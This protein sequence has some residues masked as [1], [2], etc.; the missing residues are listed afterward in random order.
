MPAFEGIV[1]SLAGLKSAE[2]RQLT[3][4]VY[5][6]RKRHLTIPEISQEIGWS[7]KSVRAIIRGSD[8]RRLC[9]EKELAEADAPEPLNVVEVVK[10]AKAD[11]ALDTIEYYQDCYARNPEELWEKKGKWVDPDLAQWAAERMGKGIGLLEP[12]QTARPTIT[13]HLGAI[14]HVLSQV[15][16]ED[17][18]ATRAIDVTPSNDESARE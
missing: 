18:R 14:G 9:T 13:I 2:R 15:T 7:V 16:N 17:A 1:K 5:E 6:A 8:F 4:R 11:L 3:L 10:N 12:E